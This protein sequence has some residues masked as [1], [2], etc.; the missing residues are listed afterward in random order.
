M[1]GQGFGLWV[2]SSR[3]DKGAFLQS[4]LTVVDD[5]LGDSSDRISSLGLRATRELTRSGDEAELAI[6]FYKGSDVVDAV[7]AV[8]LRGE[9]PVASLDEV[10]SWLDESLRLVIADT[11]GDGSNDRNEVLP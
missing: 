10:R 5:V 11:G 3:M 4:V 9:G 7:Q 8:V 2:G 6:W 1:S